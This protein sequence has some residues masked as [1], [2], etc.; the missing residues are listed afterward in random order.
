MKPSITKKLDGGRGEEAWELGPISNY[1][2]GD[3]FGP[4]KQNAIR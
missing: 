3:D 4:V 1:L 2:Q